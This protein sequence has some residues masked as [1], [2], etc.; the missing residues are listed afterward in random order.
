ML[1]SALK[2]ALQQ[3]LVLRNVSGLVVRKPR[4]QEGD[5]NILPSCWGV[6]EARKLLNAAKVAACF[7]LFAAVLGIWFIWF[8]WVDE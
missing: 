4:T 2:A 8:L 7:L 5:E 3:E 1:H 6:E